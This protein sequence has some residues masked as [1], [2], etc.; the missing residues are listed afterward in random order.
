[1]AF[2]TLMR[3]VALL[4]MKRDEEAV[5]ALIEAS[6]KPVWNSYE[7]LGYRGLLQGGAPF[8]VVASLR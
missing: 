5:Q 4:E 6:S 7:G 3:A 2:F 1:M 8:V